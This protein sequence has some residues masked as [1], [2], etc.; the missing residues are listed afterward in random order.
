MKFGLSLN[1]QVSTPRCGHCSSLPTFNIL[2]FL[3]LEGTTPDPEEEHMHVFE[4]GN[5]CHWVGG[6]IN[7]HKCSHAC[8]VPHK[9]G[10]FV[11]YTS[12]T[13]QA[14]KSTS[15][16]FVST[17][18]RFWYLLHDLILDLPPIFFLLPVSANALI[19]TE[20]P[21]QPNRNRATGIL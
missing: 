1:N 12:L 13:C 18:C 20:S 4:P 6:I 21:E 3:H 8:I 14:S 5:G 19:V 9:H 2:I 15:M 11:N 16:E 17:M 10:T 7:Q